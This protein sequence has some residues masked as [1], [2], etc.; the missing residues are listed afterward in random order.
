MTPALITPVCSHQTGGERLQ[1][2]RPLAPRTALG[3]D[4]QMRVE[5]RVGHARRQFLAVDA[6]GYSGTNLTAMHPAIV[7]GVPGARRT[8]PR[9]GGRRA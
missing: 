9:S 8:T 7:P 2:A 6:C 1:A 4:L 3:A 5:H